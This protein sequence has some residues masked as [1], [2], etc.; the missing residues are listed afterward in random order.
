MTRRFEDVRTETPTQGLRDVLGTKGAVS[1]I[2]FSSVDCTAVSSTRAETKFAVDLR[3][4]YSASGGGKASFGVTSHA[5]SAVTNPPI[6]EEVGVLIAVC[7]SGIKNSRARRIHVQ[8]R[9]VTRLVRPAATSIESVEVIVGRGNTQRH[10]VRPEGDRNQVTFSPAPQSPHWAPQAPTWNLSKTQ[11]PESSTYVCGG[12]SGPD[13]KSRWIG[14]LVWQ[15]IDGVVE[16]VAR[17]AGEGSRIV[18]LGG[19]I[20]LWRPAS[21][22]VGPLHGPKVVSSRQLRTTAHPSCGASSQ[23]RRSLSTPSKTPSPAASSGSHAMAVATLQRAPYNVTI[24]F[25]L[26]GAAGS[27]ILSNV[28]PR[29]TV[30]PWSGAPKC[31]HFSTGFE[32]MPTSL[33]LSTEGYI[34]RLRSATSEIDSCVV[35]RAPVQL[36]PLPGHLPG[37]E[38]RDRGRG[39]RLRGPRGAGFAAGFASARVKQPSRGGHVLLSAW[40]PTSTFALARRAKGHLVTF[41]TAHHERPVVPRVF[42]SQARFISARD[43]CVSNSVSN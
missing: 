26:R 4:T 13:S 33:G 14:E 28:T 1:A 32:A 24:Q 10:G 17:E 35:A 39:G 31:G 34:R 29:A 3:L 30:F 36:V 25:A 19:R 5:R 2:S 27:G 40:S 42:E 7:G 12:V 20:E 22:V 41:S 15:T 11:L 21:H 8:S 37:L 16:A 38:P 23:W 43:R 9:F 6:S 18:P